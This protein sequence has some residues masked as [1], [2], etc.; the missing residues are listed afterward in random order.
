MWQVQC[1]LGDRI[2]M[3]SASLTVKRVKKWVK[4]LTATEEKLV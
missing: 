3:S 4:T 2:V 1:K